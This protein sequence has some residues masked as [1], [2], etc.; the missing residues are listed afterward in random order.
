MIYSC[1]GKFTDLLVKSTE[2]PKIA[3]FCGRKNQSI[4]SMKKENFFFVSNFNS[5]VFKALYFLNISPIGSVDNVHTFQPEILTLNRLAKFTRCITVVKFFYLGLKIFIVLVCFYLGLEI[6]IFL[7]NTFKRSIQP[8]KSKSAREAPSINFCSFTCRKSLE[9]PMHANPT[10]R[11]GG[12]FSSLLY[13][14]CYC[15]QPSFD[16][17]EIKYPVIILSRTVLMCEWY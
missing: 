10:V 12:R 5:H 8:S 4:L 11:P 3:K 15:C 7:K 9:P 13:I 17:L 6:F 2:P 1:H 14:G 16:I